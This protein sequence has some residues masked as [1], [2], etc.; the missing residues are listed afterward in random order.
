[1][2][3]DFKSDEHGRLLALQRLE[4]LDTLEEDTFEEIISLIQNVF[5]VPICAVSLVDKERQWFKAQRGL[6]VS[7]T[8]RDISFCTHTIQQEQPFIIEDAQKDTRF[9]TNPLVTSDPFIGSYC[10]IP[11]KMPDGYVI[12]SLCIIDQQPR[13]FRKNEVATLKSFAKLVIEKIELRQIAATDALTGAFA[14][15]AW[16]NLASTELERSQKHG[17]DASLMVLDVD[18]F[19]TINDT[20]GHSAGDVVLKQLAHLIFAQKRSSDIFGRFG[21][22]EFVLLMPNTHV[23]EAE[24][25]ANSLRD[26]V[27]A[28]AFDLPVI[29][30]VSISCGLTGTQA[31]PDPLEDML[32]RADCAL[33]KAKRSGR[34]RVVIHELLRREAL[35]TA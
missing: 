25:I 22:E 19:K 23:S 17:T 15:R 2:L 13:Q 31:G 4:I 10:G 24:D 6:D 26:R 12:G 9:S 1:M 5:N 28:H 7:Q 29:I 14:R 34:N 8:D 3:S 18:H 20:Y 30:D 27:R 32:E 16:V 11:L 21:G 35:Q 33:Y